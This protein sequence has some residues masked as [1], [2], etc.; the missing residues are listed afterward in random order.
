MIRAIIFDLNGIFL[1]SE[2]LNKRVEKKWGISKEQF[3]PALTEIMNVVR[4]PG[5]PSSF[6]LWQ[7]YFKR[8]KL[9]VSED[10]FFNFWFSGEKLDVELLQLSQKLRKRGIKIFVL[11]NNFKER[12]E[13]YRTNFPELSGSVDKTYF[14]WE[15]GMVK[16]DPNAWKI[17]LAENRLKPEE[18]LYFDDSEKNVLTAKKMG[19]R[20]Y[21]FE[22]LDKLKKIV[23]NQ[24]F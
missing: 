8:W 2:L 24:E 1:K 7:P 10:E 11:S 22:G 6:S 18:C 17:I 14:S 5:A 3:L 20:S 12:T 16:P 15:T 9:A 4:K 23:E 19:I 21:L 13:Y